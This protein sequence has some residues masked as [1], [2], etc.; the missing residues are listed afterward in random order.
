MIMDEILQYLT[1]PS[2]IISFIVFVFWLGA[3][4]SNLNGRIKQLEKRTEEIDINKIETKLAEIATDLQWVKL[5]L[6]KLSK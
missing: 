1:N 6:Q 3:T 2:T 5:E 4:W